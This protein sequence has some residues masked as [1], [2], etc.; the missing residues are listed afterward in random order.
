MNDD[1]RC[2]VR[3]FEAGSIGRAAKSLHISQPA[4]SR[5]LKNIEGELG[6]PLFERGGRTKPTAA[7][8]LYIQWAK[9]TLDSEQILL[10]DAHA[11]NK[12]TKRQLRIGVSMTR[13]DS[14]LPA[15]VERFYQACSSCRL[16]FV[17]AGTKDALN[18]ALESGSIDFGVL[19]PIK[20]E[21]ALFFNEEVCT[22]SLL[23]FA[24]AKR[25]LPCHTNEEGHLCIS[26]EI[27]EG[28]PFIMPPSHYHINWI[29]RSFMNK[30]GLH[31]NSVLNS[32]DNSFTVELIRRD[33]GVS[34]LPSTQLLLASED[35]RTY[36]IDGLSNRGNLHLCCRKEYR[37]SDDALLFLSLLNEVLGTQAS[38]QCVS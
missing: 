31:I 12:N 28:V 27:L 3:I 11:V 6:F 2:I 21:P 25:Q 14:M 16:V 17:S 7:G 8:E 10:R 35:F 30:Q 1:L 19:L 23:L 33:I 9:K 5:R 22:E 18:A 29:I 15:V 13:C 24:S 26:P 4:L 37:P 32:C 20:A 34:V 36:D 38:F